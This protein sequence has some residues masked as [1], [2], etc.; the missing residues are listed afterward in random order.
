MGK[1]RVNT[2]L[3]FSFISFG[4]HQL[5]YQPAIADK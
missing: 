3:P 5:P 1:G 2:A 4:N